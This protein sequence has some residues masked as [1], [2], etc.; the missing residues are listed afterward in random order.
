M[1]VKDRIQKASTEAEGISLKREE[2]PEINSKR[3]GEECSTSK[4][5]S[6]K[7]GRT[8]RFLEFLSERLYPQIIIPKGITKE[9][10]YSHS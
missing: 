2:K 10:R 4:F 3:T 5:I 6:S 9:N 7:L 1:K 8:Q